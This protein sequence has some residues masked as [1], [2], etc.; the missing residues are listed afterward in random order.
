MPVAASHCSH[1]RDLGL[2]VSLAMIVLDFMLIPWS[3]VW[4]VPRNHADY[5]TQTNSSWSG[6][7]AEI[8]NNLYGTGL[9]VFSPLQE[10][11]T[12][13]DFSVPVLL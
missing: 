6:A 10:R 3:N 5:G 12:I 13:V 8:K 2:T 4:A 1:S 9:P 7:I 11:L